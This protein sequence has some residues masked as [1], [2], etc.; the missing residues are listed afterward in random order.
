MSRLKDVVAAAK[1][2]VLNSDVPIVSLAL[3]PVVLWRTKQLVRHSHLPSFAFRFTDGG[4]VNAADLEL[5]E[6]LRNFWRAVDANERARQWARDRD[7]WTGITARQSGFVGALERDDPRALAEYL[8]RAPATPLCQGILQGDLDLRTLRRSAAYRRARSALTADRFISLMEA[9]GSLPV[10]NPEQGSFSSAGRELDV[11]ELLRDLDR[12][13]GTRILVP[14]VF[15]DLFVTDIG[16]RSFNQVDLMA[17]HTAL[18]LRALASLTGA[19]KIAEVG[20]GSGRT[21]YC[22]LRLG[23]GPV[24]TID[25]PHV[26]VLHAWYLLKALPS[27]RIWLYGEGAGGRDADVRIYPDSALE[28]LDPDVD[29]VVNQD[30]FPEMSKTA[31]ERYLRWTA[32][33]AARWLLSVN[34]ESAPRYSAAANQLNLGQVIRGYPEF[35]LIERQ[36]NWIRAGYVDGLYGVTRED[37]A[38]TRFRAS[39]SREP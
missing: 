7:V 18:R 39:S 27:V 12:Y 24:Q 38:S 5:A 36:S 37:A 29:V 28:E 25:L 16:A 35:V 15:S 2:R 34:H 11:A 31:V 9:I 10:K 6:R 22:C 4:Q 17:L 21:V 33:S 13:C 14:Q 3:L 8:V 32:R 20:A 19:R 23:L 26:A 30:S 1:F